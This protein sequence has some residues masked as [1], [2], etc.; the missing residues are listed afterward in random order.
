MRQHP[1]ETVVQ[2]FDSPAIA[3]DI[4]LGDGVF[5]HAEGLI[6]DLE[7]TDHVS[8]Q[9]GGGKSG[10]G[11]FGAFICNEIAELLV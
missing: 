3:P 4:T 9:R 5:D 2:L 6:V 7:P 8:T 1:P 11:H 10:G